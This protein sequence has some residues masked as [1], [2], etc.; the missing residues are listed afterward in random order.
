MSSS[1]SLYPVDVRHIAH[2]WKVL[3]QSFFG[4]NKYTLTTLAGRRKAIAH[5]CQRSPRTIQSITKN[6]D[7]ITGPPSGTAVASTTVPEDDVNET[8]DPVVEAEE[9][10]GVAGVRRH[11]LKESEYGKIRAIIHREYKSKIHI[12]VESLLPLVEEKV[13]VQVSKSTMYRVLRRMGF[14]YRDR[15]TKHLFGDPS[16]KVSRIRYIRAVRQFRQKNALIA[17]LDETYL[18]E[19]YQFRKSW[20]ELDKEKS[21]GTAQILCKDCGQSHPS[22]SGKRLVIFDV[23]TDRGFVPGCGQSLKAHWGLP[24]LREEV[25]VPRLKEFARLY[26]YDTV[27]IVLENASYHS[28]L[29]P[30]F[31]RPKRWL[32]DHRIEVGARELVA[33]LWQK[34]TDFL[35]NHVGDRY[36]MDDYLKTGEGTVRLL[37]YHCDFNPIEKCWARRKGYVAKQN[38]TRKLPD[39]IKLWEE[40]ADIFKPEDFPK[41]FAHCIKLEDDYWNIDTKGDRI[42]AVVGEQADEDV[43]EE[44][45]DLEPLD[46]D[47]DDDNDLALLPF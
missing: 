36:Y 24:Q 47:L 29:M 14:R 16:L 27:V 6:W 32:T 41:L 34:V 20:I 45:G 3:G 11:L 1:S 44:G 39:P 23:V 33:E 26:G 7:L 30:Q 40:S 15:S 38:T 43:A 35:K 8:L 10:E 12:T 46:Q 2:L 18:I 42:E 5:L 28:R 25:V 22:G 4:S 37:P 19:N 17:F 13:G 21:T 9:M 31:R